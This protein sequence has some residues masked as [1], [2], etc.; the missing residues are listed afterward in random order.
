M[1]EVR[2][3]ATS[4]TLVFIPALNE[5]ESITAVIE[6]VHEQLP[7]ADLL[8]IDDG[9]SDAT[10]ARALEAGAV[11]ATMPFNQGVGAAQQTGY[12]YALR[13]GY[14]ICAQIDGDGQHPAQELARVVACVGEKGADMAIG[15]RYLDPGL[16]RDGDYRA[17]RP[18]ELGIRLFRAIVNLSTSQRFTDTTSGLRALNREAMELLGEHVSSEFADVE[19]LQRAARAGLRVREV[20]VRMLPRAGGDS[21]LGPLR[22]LYYIYKTLVVLL[23]GHLRPHRPG[24]RSR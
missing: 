23:V 16:T 18:R 2:G 1:S 19:L 7:D 13:E 21:F 22:S 8:V 4:G 9:S 10:G 14:E 17:S 11:V 3:F 5:E 15:S 6:D 12:L 20:P 24:A